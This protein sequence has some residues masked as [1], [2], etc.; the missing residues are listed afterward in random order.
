MAGA[1]VQWLGDLGLIEASSDLE[2]L[3]RRSTTRPAPSSCPPSPDSDHRFGAADARGAISGLSQGVGRGQLAR[4]L[5]E[6]LAYQVRAM[7]DAFVAG[8]VTPHELRCDGGAAAMDLLLE[9]QATNSRV[10]CC[11]VPRSKRPPAGRR[12]SP[13]SRRAVQVPRGTERSLARH[14]ELRAR[15]AALRRRRLTPHGS[16][17]RARLIGS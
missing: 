1:A 4:A 7:T 13:D 8:G 6:A 16:R 11:E 3:A 14:R 17:A 15:R 12:A 5:I 10:T 9:L 2:A